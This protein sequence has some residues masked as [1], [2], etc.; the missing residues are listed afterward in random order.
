MIHNNRW[1]KNENYGRGKGTELEEREEEENS[2]WEQYR[3]QT[4]CTC[5]K[6]NT[7]FMREG[8]RRRAE[9][10]GGTMQ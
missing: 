6:G 9:C 5:G 8:E 10:E 4:R 3:G 7:V 2:T 1:L